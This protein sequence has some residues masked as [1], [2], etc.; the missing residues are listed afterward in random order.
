MQEL[1][2]EGEGCLQLSVLATSI[3]EPWLEVFLFWTWL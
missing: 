1:S 2:R 3:R